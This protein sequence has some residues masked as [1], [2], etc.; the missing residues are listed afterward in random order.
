M[1]LW[2]NSVKITTTKSSRHFQG[3]RVLERDFWF[4]VL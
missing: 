2:P 3:V 4:Q 1:D